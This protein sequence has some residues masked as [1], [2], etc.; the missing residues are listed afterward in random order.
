MDSM[1]TLP[2]FVYGTLRSGEGNW[3][4]ALCG[5]TA[6]EQ[7]ATLTGVQMFD[8]GGFPYVMRSDN[9]DE[10]VVGDLMQIEPALF[11]QVMADL[12]RLEGFT[13]GSRFNLYN[14]EVVTVTTEDGK[15]HDAYV[16]IVAT[17]REERVRQ[18]CP[19]IESGDWI[20]FDGA[21]PRESVLFMR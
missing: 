2:V 6:S 16:Y 18:S 4:W 14:R 11:G 21:R 17:E 10:T 1:Q 13:P 7:V 3:S 5:R 9:P 19:R 15:T 12:D 8:Q 20:A